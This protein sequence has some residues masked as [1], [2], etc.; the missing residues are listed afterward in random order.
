MQ[1]EKKRGCEL[2]EVLAT[3]DRLTNK[4]LT[5]KMTLG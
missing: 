4:G 1:R 3:F 5:E 2:G